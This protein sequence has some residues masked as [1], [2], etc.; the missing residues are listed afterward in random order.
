MELLWRLLITIRD[1]QR[2]AD[3]R[4]VAKSEERAADMNV[5]SV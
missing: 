5:M 4:G 2:M 1:V 3:M